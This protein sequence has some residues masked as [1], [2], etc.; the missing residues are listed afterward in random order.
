MV[1]ELTYCSLAKPN[2]TQDDIYGILE[3]AGRN[4]KKNSITGCLLFY[5]H[6]FL[7]ILEGEEKMV[8]AVQ[9]KIAKDS[10][11]SNVRILSEGEK[12]ERT[13]DHWTM[14]FKELSE[15][16]AKDIGD[17]FFEDNFLTFSELVSKP[18]R[19]IRSF[20][21]RAQYMING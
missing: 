21:Q 1:Y 19:T 10:R 4:N 9:K 14:A 18:T 12:E 11:H 7:Q 17:K 16:E 5:N 20:W 8:K 2:I 6:E 3:A 13:F 15:Q